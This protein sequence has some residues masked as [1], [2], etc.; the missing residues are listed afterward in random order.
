MPAPSDSV[1]I[2]AI[3]TAVVTAAGTDIFPVV[4]GGV[5]K[6]ETLSQAL[7][8]IQASIVATANIFT[9]AQ[10]IERDGIGSTSTDGAILYNATAAAAGA[11]QWSPRLRFTG[12]GWKTT[13]TA[14]SQTVDWIAEIVP[15]QGSA[16]PTAQLRFSGQI[17]GGGYTQ[18]VAFTNEHN[19]YVQLGTTAQTGIG[20]AGANQGQLGFF[21]SGEKMRL[22]AGTG[23]MIDSVTPIG[24]GSGGS[25]TTLDTTLR[26][27]AAN[28]L[29]VNN[30]T[31]GLWA[32]VK[33][34]AR[35]AGT[36]TIL[37]GLSL[38][39]LSS[40]TP[41]VGLGISLMMNIQSSTTVDQNAGQL[42][43]EWATATHASRKARVKL[44]VYDTA[45][46]EGLRV[47]ASGTAPMIGF[48]GANASARQTGGENV[49]NNVTSGGTTGQIDDFAGSVY[50]TDAPAIRNDIYQLARL[51]KQDH[52]A[53]RLYG[54]L[55]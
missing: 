44:N 6:R 17:N 5:T 33:A 3:S 37:D 26:R 53:L 1:A 11:Q 34:G 28:T 47:E 8:F 27:N 19:S 25:G 43:A 55:T 52:D 13:A 9:L 48:L 35:D 4:Q 10:T 12:Q 23:L 39:R 20:L 29:E 51:V 41:D 30:G 21:A 14:A 36:T 50:A 18:Y 24:W 54:L 7:T 22:V 16:N 2:S 42:T 31:S 40:G 46:R 38:G 32:A 49:T 45:V 15:V